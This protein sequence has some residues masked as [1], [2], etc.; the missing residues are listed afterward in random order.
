M[1]AARE[2]KQ[3]HEQFMTFHTKSAYCAQDVG[4]NFSVSFLLG[5]DVSALMI[6]CVRVFD[7]FFICFECDSFR[8]DMR[9]EIWLS[10]RKENND[11][12]KNTHL[13]DFVDEIRFALFMEHNFK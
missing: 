8:L 11:G 12:G 13:C 1:S 6:M 3:A 9:Y 4:N 7:D 2:R 5:F 10:L